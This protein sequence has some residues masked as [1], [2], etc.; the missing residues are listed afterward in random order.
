VT[1]NPVRDELRAVGPPPSGER[2]ALLVF[3]GSR[4]ARSINRAM[5][6][7]LDG[8]QR[9][10]PPPRV[11]HQTGAADEAELRA[12][13]G[14]YPEGLYEV[15]AFL[16]DMP[17]RLSAADLVVC[18]AGATTLAELA[19]SGRPAILVPYPHAADDHQRHN[20][21]TVAAAGAALVIPDSELDPPRLV[22]AIAE[23]AADPPRRERMA[24]AARTLARPD[25][26]AA[27]ADLAE[28]L[29]DRSARRD[30][31]VP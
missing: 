28:S 22:A 24:R 23:L 27:I 17:R 14:A 31:R 5:A 9:I 13:A 20:A 15:R 29:L 26:A 30:A 21:E 12:A 25:A 2:L 16:D 19:V 8:L 1:G 4:G 7:S 3:G 18:R 6:G 11:V 10:V